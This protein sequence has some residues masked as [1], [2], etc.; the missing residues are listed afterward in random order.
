MFL[1]HWNN[2]DGAG[3]IPDKKED[4]LSF[5]DVVKNSIIPSLKQALEQSTCQKRPV[6]CDILDAAGN[7]IARGS[8]RCS[9]EGGTCHRLGLVQGKEGYDVNSHCNWSHAEIQAIASLTGKAQ[10]HKAVLY[11]HTFFCDAC[12]AELKKIGVTEFQIMDIK[13]AE[14]MFKIVKEQNY[15]DQP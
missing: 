8:N 1:A 5:Y 11:G 2:N 9:P 12:E 6:V 15:E 7:L 10:P 13:A 14:L 4:H 3:T